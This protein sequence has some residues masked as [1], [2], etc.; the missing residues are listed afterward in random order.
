M[1]YTTY[2]RTIICY[3]ILVL[4]AVDSTLCI[5]LKRSRIRVCLKFRIRHTEKLRADIPV[6]FTEEWG[7][8]HPRGGLFQPE[9]RIQVVILTELRVFHRD[10]MLAMV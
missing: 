8:A 7:R 2:I 3:M 6:M 1:N 5:L 9:A 10:K 4:S